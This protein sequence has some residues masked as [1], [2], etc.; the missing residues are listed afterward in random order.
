[1]RKLIYSM[2]MSLDGYIAAPG[3]DIVWTA[4]DEE[5]FRFH[6]EQ[7]R[8]LGV[9][10]LGRRLYEAM[11]YW[12]GDD[13]AR[14]PAEREFTELWRALPKVAYS[15]TLDSVEGNTRLAREVDAEEIA[16]MKREQGKDLA[17]GGA[18]LAAS[19]TRLG[20]IDEYHLF[21]Y[22]VVLGGGTRFFPE[23][24]ERIAL[25][26]VETRT[27]REVVYLRYERA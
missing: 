1:M 26:L 16:A 23:L 27:F 19:F 15:T 21:V 4:P 13:P 22:P 9:H 17:V 24:E 20:L 3:D 2:G 14:G 11:V 25:D 12:E 6:T 5:L 10:F 7:V 8:E 18:G